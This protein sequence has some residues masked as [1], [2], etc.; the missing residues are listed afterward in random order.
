MSTLSPDEY[1]DTFMK[2]LYEQGS[3]RELEALVRQVRGS[4]KFTQSTNVQATIRE[5][6]HR[7]FVDLEGGHH[8]ID[9]SR[10]TE[11]VTMTS[12]RLIG[13][14]FSG[15]L[16]TGHGRPRRTDGNPRQAG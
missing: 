5:A 7:M 4:T 2:R 14:G 6:A 8:D 13:M 15:S 11:L 10:F 12:S 9:G 1:T 3:E 16:P